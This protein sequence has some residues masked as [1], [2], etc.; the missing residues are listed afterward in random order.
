VP[1]TV[2]VSLS[3][4]KLFGKNCRLF[5]PDTVYMSLYIV[6]VENQHICLFGFIQFMTASKMEINDR[7]SNNN[8]QTNGWVI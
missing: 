8:C 4:I 2:K 1:K 7:C 5:F 6:I 3:L